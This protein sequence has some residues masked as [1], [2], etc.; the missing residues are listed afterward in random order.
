MKLLSWNVNGLRAILK[1]GFLEWLNKESPDVICLQEIKVDEAQ[2]PKE[3][4]NLDGYN[5]FFCSAKR[6]GYSGTAIFSKK[7]PLKVDYGIGLKEQDDE[8]RTIV[9]H[10]ENFSLINCY[11]PNSQSERKRLP[12]KL[13]FCKGIKAYCDDLIKNGQN[14]ILCGDT[15]IAHKPIDLARPDDNEDSPGYYIEERNWMDSF[16][17]DNYVDC[18]RH[19]CK[20]PAQYTWWSYRT[21]A[22]DRNIGWRIDGHY[23]N[24]DFIK[25][26]KES[27]ILSDVMGSDHCPIG[28]TI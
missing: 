13:D 7:N 26:I 27:Y 3:L 16:L 5:T 2:I 28:L 17:N 1:K 18:F 11:F 10:Y 21:K 23:V 22:R 12:F 14:I 4:I 8:G 9:A 20:E 19:F 25:S 24:K 6:R 15:N